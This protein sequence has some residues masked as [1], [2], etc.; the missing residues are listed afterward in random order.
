MANA[1]IKQQADDFLGKVQCRSQAPFPP[2]Q[3]PVQHKQ[4]S[5]LLLSAYAGG[6]NSELTALTQY[7]AH[8]QTASDEATKNL[9]LCVALDEMHHLQVIGEMIVSLGGDLRFWASN[10]AY[11]SGGHVS[12]GMTDPEKVSQ[13]IFSEQMAIA[14]YDALLRE[15]QH[16]NTD[17][18]PS[19]NQVNLVIG[20]ILED[21]YIHL[22]QF[23]DQHAK[24]AG[25]QRQ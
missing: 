10:H 2:T 17:N 11:W 24:L 15:I 18:N 21:E 22:T 25:H 9:E 6:G 16:L 4:A 7:F 14:G 20:R 8:S 1:S 19:L 13:D 3:M 23:T 12:Y 5:E